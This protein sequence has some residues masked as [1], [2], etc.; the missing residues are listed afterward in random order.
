MAV[1]TYQ[2]T[3]AKQVLAL[4]GYSYLT[5]RLGEYF[6]HND[7]SWLTDEN[8]S[9]FAQHLTSDAGGWLSPQQDHEFWTLIQEAS[10]TEPSDSLVSWLGALLDGWGA[11]LADGEEDTSPGQEEPGAGP[12]GETVP[13]FSEDQIA[14]VGADYPDWWQGYDQVEGVWKYLKSSTKPAS[15]W[16][17]W[18]VS[19]QAFAIMQGAAD[20]TT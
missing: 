16:T 18:M 8:D 10:D 12:G 9:A 13:R 5:E 1:E 17:G 14:P 15:D 2:V 20:P 3:K 4:P 7:S 19:D 6:P 11:A